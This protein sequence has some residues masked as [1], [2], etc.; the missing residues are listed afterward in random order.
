MWAGGAAI[1]VTPV[2]PVAAGKALAAALRAPLALRLVCRRLHIHAALGQRLLVQQ[3]L[4][5]S[6]HLRSSPAILTAAQNTSQELYVKTF[7]FV[8][9]VLAAEKQTPLGL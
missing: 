7:V 1:G 8:Q 4:G 2:A 5:S 3:R 6:F 9:V